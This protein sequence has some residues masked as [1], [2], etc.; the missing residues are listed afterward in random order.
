VHLR[1]ALVELVDEL[2]DLGV[3]AG[4]R[5][6]HH[7]VVGLI[8]EHEDFLAGDRGDA[9]RRFLAALSG[10]RHRSVPD[11]PATSAPACRRS[12]AGP[13]RLHLAESVPCLLLLAPRLIH[14]LIKS[15]ADRTGAAPPEPS[16]GGAAPIPVPA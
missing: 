2:L 4:P 1:P 6:H 15:R 8:G 13:G 3:I 5:L 14:H 7:L 11:A 9:L 16:R 10:E 12:L